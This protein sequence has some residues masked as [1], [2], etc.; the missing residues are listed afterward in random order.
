MS[1]YFFLIKFF[2]KLNN[3]SIFRLVEKEIVHVMYL[4]SYTLLFTIT[5]FLFENVF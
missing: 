5:L 2:S 3:S 1:H 4:M